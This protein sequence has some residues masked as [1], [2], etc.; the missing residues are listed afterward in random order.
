MISSS[1]SSEFKTNRRGKLDVLVVFWIVFVFVSS[2][3]KVLGNGTCHS[4]N[5]ILGSTRVY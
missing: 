1:S 4:G 3:K 5:K 2:S